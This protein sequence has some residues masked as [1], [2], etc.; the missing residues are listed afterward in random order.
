MEAM[1]LNNVVNVLLRLGFN[2]YEASGAIR[3]SRAMAS[4]VR[5]LAEKVPG[6]T[7]EATGQQREA[8]EQRGD[9]GSEAA[10]ATTI[11]TTATKVTTVATIAYQK[12]EL[13]KELLLLEKHLQQGCRIPP[14][15]GDPCDCCSP[16]HT[17]TIEALAL[18]TY[19][20]T[21]DPVYQE[22]AQ[23]ANS[24]EAKTTIREIE[25]GRHNYGEDAVKAREYRK[26]ILGTEALGALIAPREEITLEEAKAEAARIAAEE[27]EKAWKEGE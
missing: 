14:V 8:I 7:V 5:E 17:I 12:R 9:A 11:A 24:I 25:S 16:K 26:K 18:E 6:G 3:R 1:A 21:G 15:T 4:S 23:W 20:I 27:I 13:G 10:P 22:I 2:V 19:G